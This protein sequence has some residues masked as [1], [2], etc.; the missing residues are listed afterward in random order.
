MTIDHFISYDAPRVQLYGWEHITYLLCSFAIIF[1]FVWYRK[2]VRTHRKAITGI[3]LG[4][5]LFQQIFLMYGW[6]IFCT[7]VVLQDGLPLHLCRVSTLLTIWYL[8]KKDN[9]IMDVIFYFSIYALISFFYPLDVHHFAHIGGISYMIN[10]LVTVLIPIF[11][12][13][14]FDWS[15][16]WRSWVRASAAFTVYL[17]VAVIAN[18]LTGGNYF[19]LV[20]RPFWHSAPAWLFTGLAYVV[21]LAGFA[22]ATV[23]VHA[24]CHIYKTRQ[25]KK[26]EILTV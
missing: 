10:H 26:A 16:S 18:K 20:R 11:A 12:A 7:D 15:P 1:L 8:I 4:V 13:I 17:P 24:C 9:R 19:Y 3:F 23:I 14:A 21:T 2:G 6:Y 25:A 5:I 22:V